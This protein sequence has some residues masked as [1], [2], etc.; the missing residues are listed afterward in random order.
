MSTQ[1]GLRKSPCWALGQGQQLFVDPQL[2]GKYVECQVQES[3]EN[4]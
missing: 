3:F 4:V 1:T 2:L